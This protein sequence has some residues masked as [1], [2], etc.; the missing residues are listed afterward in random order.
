[1]PA[2]LFEFLEQFRIG[3]FLILKLQKYMALKLFSNLKKINQF[4]KNGTPG[5]ILFCGKN[6]FRN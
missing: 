2:K 1:M 3:A 6:N 4:E 5:K